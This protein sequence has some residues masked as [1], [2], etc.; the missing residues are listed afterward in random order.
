MTTTGWRKE[1][2][3]RRKTKSSSLTSM[4]MACVIGVQSPKELVYILDTHIV[5]PCP[6]IHQK[7]INIFYVIDISLT[8]NILCVSFSCFC[9]TKLLEQGVYK[10][11][12]ARSV[13]DFSYELNYYY[14]YYYFVTYELV[15]LCLNRTTK[16]SSCF[17]FFLA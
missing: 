1:S 11:S 3:Q 4:S 15:F 5:S 10:V 2:G 9:S 12:L 17:S 8:C 13:L 16:F 14:C 6:Y 7:S